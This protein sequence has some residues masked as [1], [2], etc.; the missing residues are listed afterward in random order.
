M[1]L[2]G[3]YQIWGQA[4]PEI[5]LPL[6]EVKCMVIRFCSHFVQLVKVSAFY[7]NL[8]CIQDLTLMYKQ[9]HFS[10]KLNVLTNIFFLLQADVRLS[11]LQ[12]HLCP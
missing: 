12:K 7:E 2:G 10:V 5:G 6:P 8:D 9:R 3:G 4:D 11:M 1:S